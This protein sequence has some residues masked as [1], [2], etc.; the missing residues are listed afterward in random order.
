MKKILM[1]ITTQNSKNLALDNN[2]LQAC[3]DVHSCYGRAF[4]KC[5][6]TEYADNA[7]G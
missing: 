2:P 4:K 5:S 6:G 1:V 7:G 3:G